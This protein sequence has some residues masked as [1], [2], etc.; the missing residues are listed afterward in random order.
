MKNLSEDETKLASLYC[1][2][3][4]TI[5]DKL[6]EMKTYFK[7][8]KNEENIEIIEDLKFIVHYLFN[9]F[10]KEEIPEHAETE[11]M[12]K[13]DISFIDTY[14]ELEV[15]DND[16][17]NKLT[18]IY[19]M[20]EFKTSR[21]SQFLKII[22]DNIKNFTI[23]LFYITFNMF[24]KHSVDNMKDNN[25]LYNDLYIKMIDD[26]N[27]K[28]VLDYDNKYYNFIQSDI[29]ELKK[30]IKTNKEKFTNSESH[31]ESDSDTDKGKKIVYKKFF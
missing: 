2:H 31:S 15:I 28:M 10:D 21:F 9:L 1:K 6:E 20:A 5:S 16:L 7:V 23:E 8:V 25:L 22:K 26:I 30:A 11:E 29:I 14:L 13:L 27:K 3:S 4:E 19:L 24:V 17:F 18:E 12:N